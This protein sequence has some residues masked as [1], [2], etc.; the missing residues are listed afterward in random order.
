MMISSD[1][2]VHVEL[3]QVTIDDGGA[4]HF[5]CRVCRDTCPAPDGVPLEQATRDFLA[6][7]PACADPD[8]HEDGCPTGDALPQ[9]SPAG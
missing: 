8:A 2:G 6:M 3:V 5:T 1:E 9:E 7:H 4:V